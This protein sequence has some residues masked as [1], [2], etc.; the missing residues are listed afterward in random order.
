[1]ATIGT[2]FPSKYLRAEDLPENGYSS[3]T[4]IAVQ[5]EEMQLDPKK[6]ATKKWVIYFEDLEKGL[7]LNKTN[8]VTIAKLY[9]EETSH[10]TGDRVGL[11]VR[12]VEFSGKVVPAIRVVPPR[13]EAKS[14]VF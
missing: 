8:A 7:V 4:I 10:W 3:L 13:K 6:T 14:D 11:V 2:M 5:E 12:E 9:G 1:M